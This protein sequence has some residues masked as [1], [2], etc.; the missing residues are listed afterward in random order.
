MRSSSHLLV[1]DVPPVTSFDGRAAGRGGVL[2]L[3]DFRLDGVRDRRR[4]LIE[5]EDPPADP[6]FV[7]RFYPV[8]D[9]EEA[10][11]IAE[12]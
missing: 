6:G 2:C 1:R 11:L 3:G 8:A 7:E 9:M 5:F 4:A 10:M 12:S